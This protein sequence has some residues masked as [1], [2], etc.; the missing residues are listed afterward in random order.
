M[1]LDEAIRYEEY[2]IKEKEEQAWEARL[3]EEYEKIESYLT[4]ADEHR[5]LVRW[6]KQL[7]EIQ[8]TV[9]EYRNVPME[10]MDS[11]DAFTRICGVVDEIK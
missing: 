1:T 10:V 7:Q 6:L 3:Q 2:A 5:Q 11:D 8:E 4:Y 9:R